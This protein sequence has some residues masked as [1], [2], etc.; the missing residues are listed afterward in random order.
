MKRSG[1][2]RTISAPPPALA[3]LQSKLNHILHLV[4]T[5]RGPAHGFVRE[6]SIRTNAERH[7][8]KKWVL[9]IDLEDFFPSIHFGR[10]RGALEAK[11]M[12]M[13]S[14]AAKVIAQICT[15]DGVLPQGAPTSPILANIVCSKL[16]GDLVAL[17]RRYNVWYTRYCDDLTFSSRDQVFPAELAVSTT[18]AVG[19]GVEV[20]A[21]LKAVVEGNT[22]KIN[23]EKTRLQFRTEHQ[24]VTGIT[25]NSFP[26]VS[27]SYIRAIRGMLYAWRRH[28]I[29][30]AATVFMSKYAKK[31]YS[32]MSNEDA[33]RHVLRGRIEY[34]GSIRGSTDPIYCKLR[35][36]LHVLDRTLIGPAP[37]PTNYPL[38]LAGPR[39]E[40]W[41]RLFAARRDSI[42]HLEITTTDVN[43]GTAFAIAPNR[44]ATAAHNLVGQSTC[45]IGNRTE[46]LHNAHVH[47]RGEKE[48]DAAICPC[49]HGATPVPVDRRL[50]EPGE[51][52]AIIG[53]ASVPLR[54]PD[55]G[56][57][58]G[59]VESIRLNYP[60]TTTYIHVSV[61]SGG[62]LSGS[63]AFDN[64]GRLVGV[65]VE[66]VF[67]KVDEGVPRREYCTILPTQYLL[68]IDPTSVPVGVPMST[69]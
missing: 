57:Y 39:G 12:R 64:R 28:D 3:V 4:Y 17:A 15:S 50:P 16:D 31:P 21:A 49:P 18:A 13:R 59:T 62:G 63:P 27:R 8:G 54:H 40:R 6:R 67:E 32:S 48:I 47:A 65:V 30:P 52:I 10:V 58:V 33:F 41:T 69:A 7:V 11:P 60:R 9:N 29:T 2:K 25:V 35:Q 45:H 68:E 26:N 36:S 43:S 34:V 14:E 1:G 5:P 20:G 42:F 66:S 19:N 22:F 24:E 37:T 56:L 53:F 46:Q 23:P 51:P 61:P 38:S 44:L 55:L